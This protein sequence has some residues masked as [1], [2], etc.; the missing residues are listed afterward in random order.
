MVTTL[1]LSTFVLVCVALGSAVFVLVAALPLILPKASL[2]ARKQTIE[3]LRRVATTP[4]ADPD[5]LVKHVTRL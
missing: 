4:P 2:V 5:E 1:F 3:A